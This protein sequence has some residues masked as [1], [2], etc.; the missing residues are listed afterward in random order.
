MSGKI[1]TKRGDSGSSRQIDGKYISKSSPQIVA[2]GALDEAQSWLGLIIADLSMA[3][4]EL[5]E[6][7]V[8][9]Q[10]DFYHLQADI[11]VDGSN[12]ISEDEVAYLEG[13]I[14]RMMGSVEV[15][16][17]FILPGG[18][19][20]AAQL[21]YAR[22]LA[23]KAERACVVFH[24]EQPDRVGV[25]QLKFINRLSDYLYAMARYANHLD[26]VSE[27]LSKEA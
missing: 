9:I 19:H 4:A 21:Q 11:S 27:V 5:R 26:G 17:A 18:G 23:R 6:P 10:R 3:T 24:V 25:A 7:L 16:P 20:T 2:V 22:T 1:Y 14:D 13:E 15:I 8:R 12:N